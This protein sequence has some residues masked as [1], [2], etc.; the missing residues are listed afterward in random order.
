MAWLIVIL[1]TAILVGRLRGGRVKNLAGAHARAWWL[2]LVGLVLQLVA[3]YLPA[4]RRSLAVGLLVA[5]YVAILLMVWLNRNAP[6]MWIAGIGILMNFVVISLNG[7]MPVLPASV[8]IAGGS[9]A[10]P[11]GGK[12]V[13][14]TPD[15]VVAFLGD[16]IPVPGSVI[17]LGDVFIAIGLAVF[18]EEQTRRHPPLFSRQAAS[19]SGSAVER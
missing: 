10:A 6:G 16:V 3:N 4:G 11:I 17:S 2:L 18:L 9:A 8:E 7:G 1:V 14:L 13:L 15:T 19:V 12:H 5:S